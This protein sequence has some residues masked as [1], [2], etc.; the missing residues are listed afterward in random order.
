[1]FV[2]ASKRVR[3]PPDIGYTYKRIYIEIIPYYPVIRLITF[4]EEQSNFEYLNGTIFL[5]LVLGWEGQS[6]NHI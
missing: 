4:F 2:V 3:P 5:P 6:L 1:V